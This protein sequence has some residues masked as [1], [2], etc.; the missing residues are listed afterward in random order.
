VGEDCARPRLNC[1]GV[2]SFHENNYTCDCNQFYYG[3]NCEFKK[4]PDDCK[5]HGECN[6]KNGM[7][8]CKSDY[9]GYNCGISK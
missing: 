1:S 6:K 7:C 9:T 5:G 8:V 2:G 4:C 3:L